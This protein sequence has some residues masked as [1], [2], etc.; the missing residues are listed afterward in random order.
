MLGWPS[1]QKS[2]RWRPIGD[3][4][5]TK[6]L[7]LTSARTSATQARWVTPSCVRPALKTVPSGGWRTRAWSPRSPTCL[8]TVARWPTQ[9][10]CHCG[11]NI[12]AKCKTRNGKYD[13]ITS[14][15]FHLPSHCKCSLIMIAHSTYF[16]RLDF[17]LA[18]LEKLTLDVF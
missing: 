1:Q 5:F 4:L 17:F 8:T 15:H 3:I 18:N 13:R 6:K 11:V 16:I 10:S 12:W 2:K 14:K 9:F 7:Y